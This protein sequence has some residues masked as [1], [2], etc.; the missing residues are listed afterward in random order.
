MNSLL[1]SSV[2]APDV[3]PDFPSELKNLSRWIVH[4]Q[5]KRPYSIVTA[6]MMINPADPL[7]WGSYASAL[8]AV[9][10]RKQEKLGLG[11]TLGEGLTGVD[12]DDCV[13]DG[14]IRAD[15]QEIL[16]RVDSYAEFFTFR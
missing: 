9:A 11:I 7:H 5:Q 6:R 14:V 8:T 2:A 13:N 1:P 12:F 3:A 15:V 16:N 4:D 10:A